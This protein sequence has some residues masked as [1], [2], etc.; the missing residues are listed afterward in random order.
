MALKISLYVGPWFLTCARIRVCL[1]QQL[2]QYQEQQSPDEHH[3]PVSPDVTRCALELDS[4]NSV[5]DEASEAGYFG[6]DSWSIWFS[7]AEPEAH[8]SSLHPTSITDL[9]HQRAAGVALAGVFASF[10]E[11]SAHH[12]RADVNVL[13]GVYQKHVLTNL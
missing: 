3:D 1:S 10:L 2:H 9:T 13:C 4:S 7:A 8:N 5:L 6:I 12:V 11:S